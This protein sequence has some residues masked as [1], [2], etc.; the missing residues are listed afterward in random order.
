[1]FEKFTDKARK[2][3][4]LAQDEARQLGQMYVGT[5]H[6]LL[7]LIKEG[8]GIA[9]QALA[10]LDV[11]YDET[12]ACITEITKRDAEPVPGGHIP[13][14]PRAKRVLEGAY[15]ET[16]THGQ[17]YISTEHLLLGIVREGNGVA[18]EAL[19]R[20]GVSGDAVRNA[21]NE[22]I[23]KNPDA[24][25]KQGVTEVRIG[26]EGFGGQQSADDD[27][28]MLEEYG[29]NLTKLASDG[30]LDPVIGRDKEVE[31]V[32]QVL[33]RRQKNNP[34][35]LGDPG[36]GKTAIAEGLAQLIASGNVPDILRNKQIWTLD[37]AALVAGSKYRGEFEDRLKKVIGEVEESKDDIL[38]IDELHTLIGAGSAEGSID[39]ASILKPPLS[40]GEI[41]VIGATTAEEYRKHIEKDSAFERRFQPVYIS[42][43]SPADTLRILE[44]LRSRYE[45]HHH[46]R[47]TEEALKAAVTLSNRYVQDRFLPDK[48]IDV[49]DEAG[50]R[51]RVHKMVLPPEIAQVDEDLARVRD[52]KAVA[53]GAQEYEEAARLRDQ[54]KELTSKR[55]ELE[56]AWH[57]KLDE[58]VVTVDEA[59]IADVVS[60]ITGVPVSNLTEAE[61]SKLLRCEDALHKRVIG[62][63]EAVTAVA[64][65]IRRSRSPLKDP[66]RPGGSFVFLGPSGVGKTELAKSLA[67][68]LFGSEDSLITFDMSEF[69]EK[70]AVSKLVGAP[71]GY[72][73]Y[74]EGGELTKAVRRKPYSVV[75]FDEIEKAHPDVFNILLQILDE[76]RLT[77]GQGRK[78]DFSNTVIIMTSNVGARD[79]AQTGTIGFGAGGA[80]G[81]SDREIK[82]RVTG[83]LKKLFRPEFLNRIDEVVVFKSL[84]PEQLR[85]I[86]D[87]M[88][89]ELR[90]RL[91]G[92]GMSIELTD[93][94]RDLVAKEGTD[95]VYGARPLRRAIQT[96]VEDPLAEQMLEGE[97]STGDIIEVD[98]V[99]GKLTFGKGAGHIDAAPLSEEAG[100]PAGH[101]DAPTAPAPPAPGG[102]AASAE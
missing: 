10:K 23:E 17:T 79:I 80:G 57:A 5:E 15:R 1:M 102:A 68:F 52:E 56:S 86:V 29:R 65:A 59:E 75:L 91:I 3:M 32:M 25:P 45:E 4:S 54:E 66:R 53:A 63:D 14:T 82:Q 89:G 93:A 11:T 98:A 101:G 18:M 99:D 61:A 92:Q 38:F 67:Q 34:L 51:T 2:V 76:G 95:P 36:V 37:V 44:G 83:E 46:V 100:L 60:D 39:A 48:A 58:H 26:P 72:V 77:D 78:V 50:A 35:I 81:L 42:E 19:S 88:V 96:L 24:Q 41:Q 64:R 74:D 33:A 6:L 84:T 94:A 21:V 97:W 12:R 27:K 70:F 43:P 7:G 8:D 55:E 85:R 73:G 13:F 22:L 16:M 47:Y 30:R 69:M 28:S 87:L 90:G 40:R 20:M 31:R 49:I 71:P 9:A 62:Q